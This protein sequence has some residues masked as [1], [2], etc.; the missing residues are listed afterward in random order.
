MRI[1]WDSPRAAVHI[2]FDQHGARIAIKGYWCGR[3]GGRG[4]PSWNR[5]G[6]DG[7][8]GGKGCGGCGRAP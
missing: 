5:C 1:A 2:R 4:S 3:Q 7:R 8:C 6:G